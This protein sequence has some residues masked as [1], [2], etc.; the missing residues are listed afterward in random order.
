VPG[1]LD[2]AWSTVP[3][4]GWAQIVALIAALDI[5]VFRQDPANP[6][7]VV[8]QDLQIVWVRYADPE[9]KTFKLNAERNNGRAAMFGILGMI[10]H[11][12][13]GQDALF[14]IIS[15]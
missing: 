2:G 14:P 5:A 11:A 12:A 4:S 8:V 7:G 6:P 1:T 15:K 10:S 13:L 9:V 3:L